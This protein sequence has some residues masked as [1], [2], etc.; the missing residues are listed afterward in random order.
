MPTVAE[1]R[2][3]L[4]NRG[5]DT[6]GKKQDLQDRLFAAVVSPR[7]TQSGSSHNT[8]AATRQQKKRSRD[9]QDGAAAAAASAAG[10]GGVSQ[11]A[12]LKQLE[13]PV[14]L[15][16]IPPPINQCEQGHA[17]C[18]ECKEKL[19]QP[20]KCPECRAKISTVRNLMLE[21]L[22]AKISLPCSYASCG[23]DKTV[24]YEDLQAHRETCDFRPFSCPC[25]HLAADDDDDDGSCCNFRGSFQQVLEHLKLGEDRGDAC[26]RYLNFDTAELGA[27]QWNAL[28]HMFTYEDGT[29]LY[30]TKGAG[31]GFLVVIDNL[32]EPGSSDASN[33]ELLAIRVYF[34][35]PE[36][37]RALYSF[38]VRFKNEDTRETRT[39]RKHPLLC[40]H[41]SGGAIKELDYDDMWAPDK[42]SFMVSQLTP[43]VNTNTYSRLELSICFAKRNE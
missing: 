17:L 12:L 11:E 39:Y 10:E 35:G 25:R 9:D 34:L 33:R 21:Q 26:C 13:C 5:L 37:E 8:G 15:E 28:E 43:F 1:L 40:V 19:P 6:A 42:M 31:V 38:S 23:C 30:Q 16:T 18:T 32:E 41:G 27:S 29:Y 2:A 7:S 14:C 24:K 3:E 22:V 4:E 36:A 20:R